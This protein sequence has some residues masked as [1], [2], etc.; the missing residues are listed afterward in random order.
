MEILKKFLN[1]SKFLFTHYGSEFRSL[2]LLRKL[3]HTHSQLPQL[4][5]MIKISA[6]YPLSSLSEKDRLDDIE[7]HLQRGNH[8]SATLREG[9]ASLNKAYNKEGKYG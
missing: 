1:T 2:N 9:M 3:L 7:F 4:E 8:K 6:D 5:S